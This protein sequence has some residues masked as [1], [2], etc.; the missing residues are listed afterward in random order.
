MI[1][2]FEDIRAWISARELVNQVY[3]TTKKKPFSNDFSLRDQIRRAAISVMSN[4]VEGFDAGYRPEFIRFLRLAFRSASEVQSQLYTALD[5]KY[6][7][8]DV[9]NAVY[10]KA[11][12]V[13]KQIN[14]FITYLKSS[15]NSSSRIS[16]QPSE[17]QTGPGN[18]ELEFDVP[19]TLFADDTDFN[20]ATRRPSN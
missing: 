9:F 19:A 8:N 4:I 3:E 20:Q 7:T 2:R 18:E 11:N 17:Y 13:K 16:E 15:K 14:A 6:I 12:Q 1:R 10:E 5:Q